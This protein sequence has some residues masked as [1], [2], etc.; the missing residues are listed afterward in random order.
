MVDASWDNSGFPPEKKRLGTGM[1]VLMGCGITA[2]ILLATCGIGVAVLRNLI[3][4]DPKGFEQRVE[5]FAQGLIQKDWERLRALVTQLQTD[6]GTREV[7][8]ANPGLRQAHPTEDQFL[9]AVRAWRPRLAPLPAE[10]PVSRHRRRRHRQEEE[11][12][13]EEAPAAEGSKR[14]SVDLQKVFGNTRIRCTYPDGLRLAVA[15]D[16]ERIRNLSV[17]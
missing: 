4:K 9:Q 1:K 6:E 8:R 16:G 11:P 14:L 17:E 5:G 13:P 7:Y 12:A 10:V 2:L 15:F 3:K